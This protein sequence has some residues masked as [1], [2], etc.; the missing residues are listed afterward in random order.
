[1]SDPE[2]KDHRSRRRKRNFLAKILFD[3]NEYRGA[4]STKVIQNKQNYKRERIRPQD[5]HEEYEEE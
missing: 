2:T 5:I 4:F 3:P 1:M